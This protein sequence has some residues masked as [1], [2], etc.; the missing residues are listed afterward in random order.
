VF[1]CIA[2]DV[3]GDQGLLG[4]SFRY[5]V[6]ERLGR[7]TRAHGV[8]LLAWGFAA[9]QLRVVLDGAPEEVAAVVKGVRWGTVRWAVSVGLEVVL[10]RAVAH[11]IHDLL[12]ALVWC[13]RA[14]VEKTGA[15]P[16][17]SPWSSHR[18][19]MGFRTAPF[20]DAAVL[21]GRI[22]PRVVHAAAGGEPLPDGWPPPIAE[23]RK[24]S[25]L[26][27]L[28]GA[29]LGVLPADRRCFRLF[30]HL[31]R[32]QGYRT[33]ELA[34]ALAMTSRRVRQ[35]AAQDEPVLRLARMSLGSAA[36]CQVP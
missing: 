7:V 29:V 13:H 12:S 24:L 5:C 34:G 33:V 31:A 17:E 25:F 19:L 16:I 30:V 35:L 9:N 3:A 6:L 21:E 14:P 8:A 2:C 36:L 20:Y 10:D 22:D 28:S 18:D 1:Q 26:L 11:A 4:A 15:D 23:R 32:E 27:R